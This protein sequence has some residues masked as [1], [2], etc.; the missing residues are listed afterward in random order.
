LAVNTNLNRVYVSVRDTDKIVTLDGNDHFRVMDSQ[1]IHPCGGTGA[2]PYGMDFNPAN[3]KLYVAC[4]PFHNVN[5]TAV[6]QASGSG[7]TRI[8]YLDVGNGG[9][10]GGGGVAVDTTTGN[11]FFTNS[12]DNTVSVISGISDS[13]IATIPVGLNPFGVAVDPITKR[14]FVGNRDSN[15]LYAI[16]DT[17]GP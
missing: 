13:V 5:K 12:L 4:A 16:L 14:V 10:D 9:G 6:F 8:A 15:N 3:N 11:V 7:L 17:Y 1:T 2:A